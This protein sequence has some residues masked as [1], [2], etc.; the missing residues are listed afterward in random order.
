M[1]GRRFQLKGCGR[2]SNEAEVMLFLLED[3]RRVGVVSESGE[4]TYHGTEQCS[5]VAT[6]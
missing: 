3:S 1:L 5:L 6:K 2:L 4:E